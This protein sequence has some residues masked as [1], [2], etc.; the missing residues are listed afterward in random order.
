[1]KS[2]VTKQLEPP[3]RAD[4][5]FSS[6]RSEVSVMSSQL[7]RAGPFGGRRVLLLG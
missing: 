6:L 3:K 1:M 5:E 4:D 2:L 7:A